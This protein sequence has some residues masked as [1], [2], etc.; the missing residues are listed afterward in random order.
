MKKIIV[1]VSGSSGAPIAVHLLKALKAMPDIETHLVVSDG[2]KLTVEYETGMSYDEFCAL[3]DVVYSK[4]D[5]G[6]ATASGTF[7][8]EGMVIV[9]CSMKTLA[10]VANGFAENLLLRSADVALKERRKLVLVTRETPLSL[11][12]IRNMERATEAGAIILPPAPSFYTNP[13]T[14]EDILDAFTGKILD[15]FGIDYEEYKRWS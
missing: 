2:G 4:D 1:G 5:I 15:C 10:G 8:N 9:P 14:I 12:H 6:A 11:I 7:K 13:K 3:A